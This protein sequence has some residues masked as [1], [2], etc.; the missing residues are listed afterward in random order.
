MTNFQLDVSPVET[1]QRLTRFVLALLACATTPSHLARNSS[2]PLP[3]NGHVVRDSTFIGDNGI[4]EFHY[5]E[6]KTL[7]LLNRVEFVVVFAGS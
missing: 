7:V 1:K 3:L 6:V 4:V 2:A 5:H